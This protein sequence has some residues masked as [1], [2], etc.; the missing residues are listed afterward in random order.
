MASFSSLALRSSAI[1]VSSFTLAAFNCVFKSVNFCAS[2]RAFA[3]SCCKADKR[4][5]NTAALGRTSNHAIAKPNAAPTAMSRT[6]ARPIMSSLRS[7]DAQ[8]TNSSIHS[9]YSFLSVHFK[10]LYRQKDALLRRRTQIPIVTPAAMLAR[11]GVEL[12]PGDSLGHIFNLLSRS[13]QLLRRAP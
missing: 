4:E 11:L 13:F 3:S 1:V 8:L 2:S 12:T 10:R 5:F 7:Q 9:S 6:F